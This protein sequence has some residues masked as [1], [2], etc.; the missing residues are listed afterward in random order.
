MLL[1]ANKRSPGFIAGAFSSQAGNFQIA[2][3]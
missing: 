3:P 1:Q 2:A